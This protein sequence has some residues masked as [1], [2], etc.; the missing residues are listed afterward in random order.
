MTHHVA[1]RREGGGHDGVCR[2]RRKVR[3]EGRQGQRGGRREQVDDNAYAARLA[4]P[5]NTERLIAI[6]LIVARSSF[7]K[8]QQMMVH[9]FGREL[10]EQGVVFCRRDGSEI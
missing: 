3:R 9:T 4:V 5:R 2:E 8:C 6:D 10:E 7:G 1:D